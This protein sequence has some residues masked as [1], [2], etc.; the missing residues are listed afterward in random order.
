[1]CFFSRFRWTALAL[2]L[3]ATALESRAQAPL[4][5]L[6]FPAAAPNAGTDAPV[7]LLLLNP[8]ASEIT[9]TPEAELPATLIVGSHRWPVVL[10][11][12][13]SDGGQNTLQPGSFARF[14]YTLRLPDDVSGLAVLEINGPQLMRGAIEIASASEQP[15]RPPASSGL[16]RVRGRDGLLPRSAASRIERSFRDHFA[17]HEPVY[18][19]YGWKE[20]EAKF[21]LSFKYR[22][23]GDSEGDP[24]RTRN[25][26][27]FGYTQR[28]LWAINANSS[29]FYDTSYM[30]EFFY[31]YLTP[32][33]PGKAGRFTFLG[34]QTGYGHE[35]NGRDGANSR[36]LNTVFFRPAV[37]FGRLDGWRMILAPRVFGYILDLSDNPD[38]KKYRGYGELRVIIGKNEGPELLLTG[39]VGSGWDFATYQADLTIPLRFSSGDFASYFLVQYFNGY[40][41]SLITYREKSSMLRAGFSFVR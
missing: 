28:S 10:H 9:Y 17:T 36:S 33:T 4:T 12:A 15:A 18:F 11:R 3:A 8:S 25:S 24:D 21:Q 31:E 39:R 37:A 23:F 2:V 41:E 22:L 13:T 27:H 7:E 16:T 26:M 1:M 6:S 40:G 35:S 34:L 14:P 19:L 32:E 30:P 5:S 20:P 38:I 29:P